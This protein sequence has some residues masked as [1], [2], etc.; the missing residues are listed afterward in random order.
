M[1]PHVTESYQGYYPKNQQVHLQGGIF[2]LSR[3]LRYQYSPTIIL[4]KNLK[5][6][7]ESWVKGLQGNMT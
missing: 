1:F 3:S 6:V 4:T 7:L 2:K 5:T